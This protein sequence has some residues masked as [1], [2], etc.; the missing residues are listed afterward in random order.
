M[1]ERCNEYVEHQNS[2]LC[3]SAASIV[4][5]INAAQGSTIFL[6]CYLPQSS[7]IL[8]NALWYKETGIGQKTLL[9][10]SKEP[11]D[12][13]E[14]LQQIYPL[15]QDQSVKFTNVLMEDSGTYRCESP[16]GEE[17]SVVRV[18]VTGKLITLFIHDS[19]HKALNYTL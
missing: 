11:M 18:T 17:L 6:P 3:L 1:D 13:L 5:D 14:R 7:Q 2:C 19:S 10:F 8:V 15:D 12:E 16:E 9:H 4:Y